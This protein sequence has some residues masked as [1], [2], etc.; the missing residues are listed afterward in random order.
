MT[1]QKNIY[2]YWLAPPR[3]P[4]NRGALRLDRRIGTATGELSLFED[5][6]AHHQR[7]AGGI[8]IHPLPLSAGLHGEGLA[9]PSEGATD[10]QTKLVSC[11]DPFA[12]DYSASLL[13]NYE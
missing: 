6:N 4:R 9:V 7:R 10:H 8:S 3:V 12:R 1:S 11:P 5:G 13:A 2:F